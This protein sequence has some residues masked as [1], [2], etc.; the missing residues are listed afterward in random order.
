MKLGNT[1]AQALCLVNK[2]YCIFD[3]LITYIYNIP[4]FEVLKFV[5]LLYTTLLFLHHKYHILDTTLR[6]I[7]NLI[8]LL[9]VLSVDPSYKLLL[10]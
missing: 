7:H 1:I 9:C 5:L 4:I 6:I 8:F 10:L 3:V 2:Y